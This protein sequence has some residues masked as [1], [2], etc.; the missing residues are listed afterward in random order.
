R[1]DPHTLYTAYDSFYRQS[2]IFSLDIGRQPAVITDEL[3]LHQNGEA[4][5]LDLEGI[6]QRRDGGFWAVSEGAGSVDDPERPVA[7]VNLL[8]KVAPDGAIAEEIPLPDSVNGLQRRF[9]YEGVASVG[10]GDQGLVYV[11]FQREWVNDPDHRVRIGRYEAATGNWTFFYYPIEEPTSPNG[12]WVGLSELVEL[13]KDSFVVVERDNQAG[14]NA[15]IKRIY[16]FSIAGFDPQPQGGVFP[17]VQKT[18]V[19]DLMPDLEGPNGL[20]IEK[21]EGLAVNKKGRAFI[22]TDNDGVGDS[23]GE[24]QFLRLGKID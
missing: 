7:S 24:T 5:D 21:V 8:L 14:G 16:K 4:V 20:V 10:S 23:S 22:V 15:R 3:V 13:D 11:A 1:W 2:R 17:L 12:G 19:R 18:P 9:G 6:A